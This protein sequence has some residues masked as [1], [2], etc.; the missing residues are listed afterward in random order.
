MIRPVVEVKAR[1]NR[2]APGFR[3]ST[4]PDAKQ[5]VDDPPC[6]TREEHGLGILDH[7]P[8][9]GS[10]PASFPAQRHSWLT[11]V[12]AMA[13]RGLPHRARSGHTGRRSLPPIWAYQH[14]P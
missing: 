13:A 7:P 6:R 12:P 14:A 8:V 5:A 1:S 11:V 9:A 10:S 2:D 3:L 4:L